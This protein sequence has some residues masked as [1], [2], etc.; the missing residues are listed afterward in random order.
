MRRAS[1]HEHKRAR[2][3]TA[4]VAAELETKLPLDHV[5]RLVLVGVGVERWPLARWYYVLERADDVVPSFGPT[6]TALVRPLMLPSVI[7]SATILTAIDGG[8]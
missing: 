4:K 7:G 3:R 6:T 8:E 2:R 5:P 1:R